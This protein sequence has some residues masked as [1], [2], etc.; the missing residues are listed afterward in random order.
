MLAVFFM[1]RRI[2]SKYFG[3]RWSLYV[4]RNKKE[5]GFAM[6]SQNVGDLLGY[7]GGWFERDGEPQNNYSFALN[8]NKTNKVIHLTKYHFK[9]DGLPTN[10]LW[11]LVRSIDKKFLGK[12]HLKINEFNFINVATGKKVESSQIKEIIY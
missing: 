12:P 7:I 8:F 10:E 3:F 11:N 9:E 1:I 4:L 6:H 2:L 5:L